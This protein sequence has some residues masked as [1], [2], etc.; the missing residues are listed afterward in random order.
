M[1]D[2][3]VRQCR[4]DAAAFLSGAKNR[5]PTIPTIEY[6]VGGMEAPEGRFPYMCALFS[7]R[8]YKCGGTLIDPQWVLTVAHCVDANK[9][10]AV[11]NPIVF[12]GAYSNITDYNSTQ[13][14]SLV[15]YERQE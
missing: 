7:G 13:V 4:G 11:H 14:D 10:D 3:S 5:Q 9:F 15:K 6:I 1:S 12:C 2:I 8:K